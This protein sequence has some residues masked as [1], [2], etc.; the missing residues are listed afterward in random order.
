MSVYKDWIA[1]NIDP[2]TTFGACAE[3]TLEMQQAF[4]ELVRVRGHYFDGRWGRRAHWWLVDPQGAI[5]DP[6]ASQ[7]PSGGN[8]VYEQ[9]EEG[10]E[11]PCGHCINCGGECFRSRGGNS[12]VC[13]EACGIEAKADLEAELYG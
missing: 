6:T 9:W 4:P 7:F 8:G 10:A 3:R 13:S 11:E 5:V 2:A 12:S 1:S